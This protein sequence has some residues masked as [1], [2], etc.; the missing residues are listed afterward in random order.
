[1]RKD[2]RKKC[3]KAICEK[4]RPVD[5]P[6]LRLREDD[7]L[8]CRRA[9]RVRLIQKFALVFAGKKYRRSSQ[10][11]ALCENLLTRASDIPALRWCQLPGTPETAAIEME[12][13]ESVAALNGATAAFV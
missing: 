5:H 1:M 3:G 4:G 9:A 2:P 7:P 11:N 10:T 8:T 12:F 6:V 13:Q